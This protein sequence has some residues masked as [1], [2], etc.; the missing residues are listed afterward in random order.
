MLEVL[1]LVTL[2]VGT[3]MGPPRWAPSHS[4]SIYLG[5]VCAYGWE[6]LK[7]MQ[8]VFT[9]PFSK[10]LS[11]TPPP[12]LPLAVETCVAWGNSGP[13]KGTSLLLRSRFSLS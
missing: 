7:E 11:A 9:V 6:Q 3:G 8:K 13:R 4:A 12:S 10:A 5:T 2:P 1:Q